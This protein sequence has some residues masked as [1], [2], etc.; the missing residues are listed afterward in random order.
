MLSCVGLRGRTIGTSSSSFPL[1]IWELENFEVERDGRILHGLVWN[2]TITSRPYSPVCH[3]SK[4]GRNPMFC[5]F[6]G[7][8]RSW[9]DPLSRLTRCPQLG[10]RQGGRIE[11]HIFTLSLFFP[12]V[13]LR[14]W[15]ET[16]GRKSKLRRRRNEI[17]LQQSH[18]AR[19]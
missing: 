17:I 2:S 6:F 7:E 1:E 14:T 11:K 5:F 13:S 16:W 9:L 15:R 8:S 10:L 4:H 19:Q 18:H 3:R 12:S